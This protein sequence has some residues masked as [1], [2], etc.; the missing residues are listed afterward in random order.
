[1]PRRLSNDASLLA[2]FNNEPPQRRT[3][4][5]ATRA[6]SSSSSSLHGPSSDIVVAA[7][8]RQRQRRGDALASASTPTKNKARRRAGRETEAT[9]A[10]AAAALTALPHVT[11]PPSQL[12]SPASLPAPHNP[13]EL[14]GTVD[15]T[16]GQW[17]P[18]AILTEKEHVVVQLQRSPPTVAD[19]DAEKKPAALE[20]DATKEP[21]PPE[22]SLT[23][24]DPAMEAV[25]KR[26]LGPLKKARGISAKKA[27]AQQ[28]S[29]QRRRAVPT[30]QQK[31]AILVDRWRAR[32]ARRQLEESTSSSPDE[33]LSGRKGNPPR[34]RRR[35]A[36]PELAL[37]EAP[38]DAMVIMVHDDDSVSAL[39]AASANDKSSPVHG[40]NKTASEQ[41]AVKVVTQSS[42]ND[43]TVSADKAASLSGRANTNAAE[44]PIDDVSRSADGKATALVSSHQPS[45]MVDKDAGGNGLVVLSTNRMEKR[46]MQQ[47]AHQST[48]CGSVANEKAASVEPSLQKAS[49]TACA[50]VPN[51]ETKEAVA[52]LGSN[53]SPTTGDSIGAVN[54]IEV[55]GTSRA[56]VASLSEGVH[57]GESVA[58]VN[59][60]MNHEAKSI[61]KAERPRQPLKKKRPT[62]RPSTDDDGSSS[63]GSKRSKARPLLSDWK[64]PSYVD[65]KDPASVTD[66]YNEYKGLGRFLDQPVPGGFA[67]YLPWNIHSA[68]CGTS[69]TYPRF[70]VVKT[71]ANLIEKKARDEKRAVDDVLREMDDHSRA[72]NAGIWDYLYKFTDREGP[73]QGLK[74]P[75]PIANKRVCVRPPPLG[76]PQASGEM[77]GKKRTR[78]V[79][80]Q[81]STE[82]ASAGPKR[83]RVRCSAGNTTSQE[84]A[85]PASSATREHIATGG[86]GA[87][88][89]LPA[90]D[91]YVGNFC[92]ET[93]FLFA[94]STESRSLGEATMP[95]PPAAPFPPPDGL[96]G[97]WKYDS[98]SRVY[99]ADFSTVDPV[100]LA[101]KQFVSQLM[102]RDDIT[103]LTKGLLRSDDSEDGAI[104]WSLETVECE[105]GGCL[106]HK[107][108]QFQRIA[109][110]DGSLLYVELDGYLSMTVSDYMRYLKRRKEVLAAG[111]DR[112]MDRS[113]VYCD[114]SSKKRKVIDDV[115][116]LVIYMTDVE[117]GLYGPTL[118]LDFRDHFKLPEALPGGKWCMMHSVSRFICREVA[119]TSVTLTIA[120]WSD[121]SICTTGHGAQSVLDARRRV[122]PA[123]S[124][125]SWDRGLWPLQHG[126][127]QR[128][129]DAAAYAG[130]A[131]TRG[132]Q[133]HAPERRQVRC[134]LCTAT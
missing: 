81:G 1:M 133:A 79:A 28:R 56:S 74:K 7:E 50:K 82:T 5:P 72:D 11:T 76:H 117:L 97:D 111:T 12:L 35:R 53:N 105:L 40:V 19:E 70:R 119:S 31:D 109:R 23:A 84:A 106:L 116:D 115:V 46:T 54:P 20:T 66:A 114:H 128:S 62:K 134:S 112:S 14:D 129:G 103:L 101:T 126:W 75:S 77:D 104:P 57:S 26:K 121:P 113:F 55:R 78:S 3:L 88:Q 16:L 51:S 48:R 25:P 58:S 90:S 100:P 60:G 29:S 42:V 34:G 15:A 87:E 37:K 36:S 38:P 39:V 27:P 110:Q 45:T 98:E 91:D 89:M 64:M 93:A 47:G 130:G 18:K 41:T 102:D 32:H 10:A 96:A 63:S 95:P 123:A 71:A 85:D 68:F 17:E 108:R 125:R 73:K 69:P 52:E 131:E 86:S 99:S 65:E 59:G 8:R 94:R 122:Y 24:V 33:N 44:K 2:F 92:E 61:E 120:F 80:D 118:G 9:N 6:S 13:L 22:P 124:R 43:P 67:N 30:K 107:F 21:T 49:E 4:Q 127:L 132:I 83:A